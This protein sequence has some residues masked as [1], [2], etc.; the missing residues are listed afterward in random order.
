M[1]SVR[2]PLFI[3]ML[4]TYFFIGGL[5]AFLTPAWQAPDEPAHY[6]YVRQLVR[7]P[8]FPKLTANCYNQ[9]YLNELTS[10]RFPP[11]LPVTGLCYEFHQPPFYYL[12]G[13]P[14]FVLT[15]GRLQLLRFLSMAL[16][17]GGVVTLA[18][19]IG[20]AIFPRRP[21]IAY[22]TMAFVAFNPMHLSMLSA[23]NNDALAELILAAILFIL[24]QRIMAPAAPDKAQRYFENDWLLGALLGL[25]LGTKLTVY[26]AVPLIAVV[27]WW[28]ITAPTPQEKWQ[29]L[30]RP[31]LVIYGLALLIV[32]PWYARNAGVYGN[33]DILGL[34]RHDQIVTGQLRAVDYIADVGIWN[35]VINFSTTTFHSFWGQFGWMAVPMDGRVYLILTLLSL[36]VL[37]GLIG[38]WWQSRR[39]AN[40]AADYALSTNQRRALAL[41]GLTI[42]LMVL[43]YLWYNV[44]FRQ[45]QGRYLFPAL[46]PVGIFFTLGLREAFDLR[47]RW[48]LVSGLALAVGWIVAESLIAGDLNKWGLL[49]IGL[50]WGSAASRALLGPIQ[51]IP[52]TWLAAGCYGLLALLALVSPFCFIIPHLS[53]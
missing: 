24:V 20:R 26:L 42:F 22:G 38:F 41:M 39:M 18:F 28:T 21:L 10:Q 31:A 8:G 35:Y 7:Q 25:G 14:V 15:G 27:L 13:M 5:Y 36:M 51:R 17:G 33:F 46:I 12:L 1:M 34:I 30:A 6:N 19:L 53:P 23:I 2:S 9:N 37:G 11:D 47:W 29:K 43:G 3:T 40:H 4:I 16:L 52:A 49:I 44:D 50:A 45:F 32:L 48:W